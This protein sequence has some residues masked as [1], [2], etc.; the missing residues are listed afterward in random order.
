MKAELQGVFNRGFPDRWK[1]ALKKADVS[2]S[3]EMYLRDNTPLPYPEAGLKEYDNEDEDEEDEEV[4]A[5]R[6]A[7]AADPAHLPTGN[8]PTPADGSYSFFFIYFEQL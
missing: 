4:G 8:P 2:S 5:E 1:L 7:Q 6:E 3:L